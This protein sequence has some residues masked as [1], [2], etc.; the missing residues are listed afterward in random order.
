MPPATQRTEGQWALGDRTALN[1]AEQHKQDDDGLNV[2]ARVVDRYAVE[3]FDAIDPVDLRQRL[4]WWGLY[5]QRAPGIDGGRTGALADEEIED[6][7]FMMRVRIPGG[8]LTATQL[9]AVGGIAR[10]LGRDRADVTD[11]QNI[12]FH[13]IR[14]EDVPEIWRRLEAVG[15]STLTACGDAPR[16]IL[17]CPVAGIDASQ[18]LDATPALRRTEA[19]A[20][21]NQA[22]TNLPRKWKTAISGCST[23]CTVHEIND[24][25]FVG[26][27]GPH[28][29]PGFDLWVGGGLSTN[30]MLAQRLG[31]YVAPELVPDVWAAVTG[32]FRDHGYR[33]LRHRARLKFLVKDWGPQR[34]REVLERDYLGHALPDGP[35]PPPPGAGSRDHVG[36]H[37]QVDGRYYVGVA[38]AVGRTSGSQLLEV[39][40]LAEHFGS[41]RVR[42]TAEQ[43]LLVLDVSERDVSDLVSELSA[44][45][46]VADPSTFRRGTMACTGLEFCKLAVV[47]TKSRAQRLTAEL[48]RRLPGFDTPISINVNGCPN[49]CAR[50]QLADIG[51]KGARVDGGEGFQ[52]HLGGALGA[53]PAFG[54]KLRGL[55]VSADDLPDY[56]ERLLR[57]YLAHR[58]GEESFASWVRRADEGLIQ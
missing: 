9:R 47:E 4:R 23:Y 58:D 28:G 34:F 55:K 17:G 57:S 21:G 32:L 22:F 43:K 26:V 20:A 53:D 35:E 48:E 6:R 42:T 12:Q 30:P 5:T 27:S 8:Q 19:L 41:G 7:H 15:L 40:D 38:P 25:S 52:L 1:A 2:R 56:V 13:W 37:R 44:R 46:L 3:G 36:V 45:D 39:A 33:R 31:A 51:L 50:F 16:N 14:I 49:A 24:V 54:R 10:E 18:V 29:D 11:R